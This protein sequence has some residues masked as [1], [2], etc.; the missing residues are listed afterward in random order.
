[1]SLVLDQEGGI[2]LTM[3][4]RWPASPERAEGGNMSEERPQHPQEPAEGAEEA[5]EAP[6]VEKAGDDGGMPADDEERSVE[7]PQEPAE[8]AE[9]A[10]EAPG[11]ERAEVD[12]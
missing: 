11:A 10:E 7:H 3:R 6:G 1:L 4:E 5:E 9:E 8:G 2:I 12:S